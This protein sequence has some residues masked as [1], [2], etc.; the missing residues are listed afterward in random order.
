MG[1]SFW[2]A[3]IGIL[4]ITIPV[5]GVLRILKI[6]I[7]V[8]GVLRMINESDASPMGFLYEAMNMTKEEIGK[9]LGGEKDSYMPYWDI[10]DKNMEQLS[11]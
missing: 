4:K 11:S 5:V 3:A 7:P 2:A 9:N 8:V 6:T 10:I 1:S